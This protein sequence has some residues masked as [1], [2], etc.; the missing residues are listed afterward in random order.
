[1][2]TVVITEG[3][4]AWARD[5]QHALTARDGS[6]LR[7]LFAEQSALRDNGAL[8]WDFRQF[9]GRDAIVSMLLG[10]VD[11]A[12]RTSARDR[13]ARSRCHGGGVLDREHP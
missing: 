8:T 6:A 2:S 12:P 7:G 5:F 1:M 3:A 13:Q 9:H 4:A 10:V 11:R